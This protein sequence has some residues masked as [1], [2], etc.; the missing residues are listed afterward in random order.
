MKTLA[1]LLLIPSLT[2]AQSVYKCPDSEG[3]FSFSRNLV[4][5]VKAKR[6]L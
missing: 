3:R 1:L 6:L 5:A 4:L 2:F